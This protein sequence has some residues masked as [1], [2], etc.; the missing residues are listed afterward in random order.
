MHF[1]PDL[2]FADKLKTV[3]WGGGYIQGGGHGPLTSIY[4]M[5]ADSILSFE[6][7]TVDGKY[8]NR[9]KVVLTTGIFAKTCINLRKLLPIGRVGVQ[10]C[11]EITF[12]MINA[13]E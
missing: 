12:T 5:G 9:K 2:S 7:I 8:L 4:G 13:L 1:N 3:G 6:A 10:C 11:G